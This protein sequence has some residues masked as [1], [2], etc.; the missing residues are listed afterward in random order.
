MLCELCTKYVCIPKKV[1]PGRAAWVDVPCVSIRRASLR[2]HMKSQTHKQA[3]EMDVAAAVGK[4][5][6]K[7]EGLT[8][9]QDIKEETTIL[10]STRL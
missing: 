10:F 4:D 9:E 5:G 7:D 1:V 6:A 8:D 3:V 2:T